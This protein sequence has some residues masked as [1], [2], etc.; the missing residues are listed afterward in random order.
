[1]HN[2]S[3]DVEGER[4]STTAEEDVRDQSQVLHEV[5]FIYP[6]TTTFEELVRRLTA[7]SR[8]FSDHDRIQRAVRDLIAAG[9]L[10]LRAG[11]LVL[12]TR[13]AVNFHCLQGI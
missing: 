5:L 2:P 12:P 3:A 10:H 11:D 13:A 1:M 6:E 4:P 9:L 7:A 8:E